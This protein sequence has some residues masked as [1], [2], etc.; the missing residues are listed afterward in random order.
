MHTSTPQCLIH[1]AVLRH[2]PVP[3]GCS[4][5][6]ACSLPLT[7]ARVVDLVITELGVFRV[8]RGK[9]PLALTELAPGVTVDEVRTKTEPVFQV[10]LETA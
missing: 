10:A 9:S 2:S 7:G 1:A 8:D 4:R 6:V 5:L 3:A